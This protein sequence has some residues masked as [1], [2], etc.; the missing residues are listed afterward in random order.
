MSGS[1]KVIELNMKMKIP[2]EKRIICISDIH[3]YLD[4]FLSLL[5]KIKFSDDDILI[6][7]GDFYTKGPKIH[8]TLKYVIGL[9][10]KQNVYVIRGN[11]DWIID[12]MQDSEKEWL[13]NLP[14]II[15]TDDYIFVHGGLSL[16]NLSDLSKQDAWECMKND[17]F[18]EKDLFFDKYIV[19]GH[20]P[21]VNYC[22]QI[23]CFNPIINDEKRIIAIDGGTIKSGGQLNAFIINND[24][25]SFDCVD[26]LPVFRAEKN[27]SESGGTLNITWNDR[28]IELIEKEKGGEF[29]IYK[30]IKTG[31]TLSIPNISVWTDENGGLCSANLATDYYLPVNAGDIISVDKRFSDKIFAKKDGVAGWINL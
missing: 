2:K 24:E 28:F 9:S 14:H 3:G 18:M 26:S 10:Q 21:T 23:P 1:A 4:L 22:H 13:E 19:T 12:N 25:F 31:Q 17:A 6:L 30:H 8:E 7:L 11:C 15:K 27:Q 16:N 20:W 29:G 5:D